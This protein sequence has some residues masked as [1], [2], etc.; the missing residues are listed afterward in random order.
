MCTSVAN[1]HP[2]CRTIQDF[3]Y[4]SGKLNWSFCVSI[5]TGGEAAMTGPLSGFT[6]QVKEVASECEST[7][8]VIHTEM[9]VS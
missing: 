7:H 5:C 9:L 2:S 4:I 8:C 1:Q 3:D 6:T